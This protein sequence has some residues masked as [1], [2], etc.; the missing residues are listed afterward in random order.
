MMAYRHAGNCEYWNH[1]SPCWSCGNYTALDLHRATSH[2][3]E[4]ITNASMQ[5]STKLFGDEIVS[6]VRQH[7]VGTPL[8]IYAPFEAVHGASSCYVA[9]KPPDCGHPD[10]DELQA[11]KEYIDQQGHIKHPDR[12]TFAGMLGALDHAVGNITDA[13]EAR[14]MLQD[15]VILF[16]TDNGAP[17]THFDKATMSNWPLR[18]G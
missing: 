17:D 12:R 15:S 14:G 4:P 18:G 13:L 5:Y 8:F 7:A 16:T 3:F 11:P 1:T 6:L 10:G 9:G 2:S